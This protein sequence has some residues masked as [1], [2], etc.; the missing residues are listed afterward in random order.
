MARWV[1]IATV[2]VIAVAGILIATRPAGP[3]TD[4][5]SARGGLAPFEIVAAARDQ[6]FPRVAHPWNF[7][8]P[9]D[10][11]RHAE[12]RTE[13]WHFMGT[14]GDEA[15]RLLGAQL[16]LVRIGL[17]PAPRD[18]PSAWAA[19]EVYV[20]LLSVTDPVTGELRSATRMSRGALDLAGA[21]SEPVRL[22]IEDWLIE[23]TGFDGE[24]FDFR[25]NAASEE[26][27][28]ELEARNEQPLVKAE[29]VSPQ[30]SGQAAPFQFYWQPRLAVEGVLLSDGRRVPVLG[31]F[32]MEH[33]WGELPLPGAPVAR[34]R[35]T[36]HLDD[37][38]GLVGIRTHRR[39][40]SGTPE[41][42]GV[43]IDSGG[44]PS[45]LPAGELTL[46]PRGY[47]TSPA[48]GARYPVR[49]A[50]RVP[51]EGIELK[52]SPERE[53]QEGVEWLPFWAGA[54]RL[55]DPSGRARGTG[56]VQL[57]GYDRS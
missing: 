3:E 23:Q 54:V 27:G 14:L 19:S 39:D 10:H 9:A 56:L 37:G 24:A 4:S 50:L 17:A 55:Q 38:R 41:T 47:W 6:D 16:L 30:S 40:G 5:V 43:L 33:A 21:G 45:V 52:L 48:T 11:G 28:L 29:D 35:F 46:E 31:R 32:S 53:A 20:S 51:N 57:N 7:A 42:T 15:G 44:R 22:W 49:W 36:L 18:H 34:D 1:T 2:A 12:Y 8:F 26:F 13:W 25:L